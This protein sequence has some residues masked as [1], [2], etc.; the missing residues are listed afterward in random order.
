VSLASLIVRQL[1][2]PSRLAARLMNL[3]NAKI[4]EQA[5]ELLELSSEHRV[6]E[7]GF[8]GGVA[9]TK[10]AGRAAF[11]A[12]IDPSEAAVRAT[13]KRFHH[14]IATRR[15]EVREAFV[16][17]IPFAEG[18]FDRAL[19]VNTIYFWSDPD[20]GL[21][22]ILRMLRP[23]GRLVLATEARRVPKR[24]AKHGFTVYTEEEQVS[25]L[26]DAGFSDVRC[27]R[28]KPFVFALATKA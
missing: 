2:R 5:V 19:S 15:L 8:G 25:L 18:S 12:G 17:T 3:A 24:I 13:C 14:E 7:V 1:A 16:E 21:R 26:R 10:L 22:E 6:L 27:E 4:N 28:R 23:G 20:A 9:L 11:V